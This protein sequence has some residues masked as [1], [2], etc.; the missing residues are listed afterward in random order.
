VPEAHYAGCCKPRLRS[1]RSR[2]REWAPGT[3]CRHHETAAKSSLVSL[4][5]D[6]KMV[7]SRFKETMSF[8]M[9]L[10][11]AI[12]WGYDQCLVPHPTVPSPYR[13]V[14]P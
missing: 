1:F 10:V 6:N 9:G 7:V 12:P 3:A 5:Q 4:S 14:I 11:A 8:S 2:L 13:Y